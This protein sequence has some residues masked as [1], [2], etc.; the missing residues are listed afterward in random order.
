MEGL[1]IKGLL[2]RGAVYESTSCLRVLYMMRTPRVP[3]KAGS[4]SDNSMS[5]DEACS[6]FERGVASLL[7]FASDS[8]IFDMDV[9]AATAV[10]VYV[11]R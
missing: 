2:I 8:A 1:L 7:H 5:H 4:P 3:G 9:P 11:V 10:T 6:D